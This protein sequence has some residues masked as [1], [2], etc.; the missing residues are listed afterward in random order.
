[1]IAWHHGAIAEINVMANIKHQTSLKE[2]SKTPRYTGEFEGAFKGDLNG[3]AETATR[4]AQPFNFI[5][6]GD[7]TGVVSSNGESQIMDVKVHKATEAE[8]AQ[9]SKYAEVARTV[10]RADN[11]SYAERAQTS[12][13]AN[14]AG[15]AEVAVSA[16][17]ADFASRANMAEQ[18]KVATAANKAELA[19]KANH[20]TNADNATHAKVADRLSNESEPVPYAKY[21]EKANLATMAQYDCEGRA[22][23]EYYLT[24]EEL[25]KGLLT[26]AQA[27]ALYAARKD[28]VL[29]A[30]VRGKA[31]GCG[32]VRGNTL[33]ILIKCI[34]CAPEDLN[35]D[36]YSAI[37]F[38]KNQVV[39]DN[40]DTTKIYI[41]SLGHIYFYNI[42]ADQWVQ[43][44]S[45][46]DVELL[47]DI[48]NAIANLN[49]LVDKTSDQEI[50]GIKKFVTKL[51]APIA[52]LESDDARDVVTVHNLKDVKSEL[53]NKFTNNSTNVQ[54]Q[55]D[56]IIARLDAQ[57]KGDLLYALVDYSLTENQNNMVVG[58]RYL[59][60][61]TEDKQYIQINP[62]TF[63]PQNPEQEP[64]WYRYYLKSDNGKVT[65]TDYSIQAEFKQYAQL[66][67]AEFT[68][69]ISVPDIPTSTKDNKVFNSKQ[70]H[71]LITE[72]LQDANLAQY[73]KLAGADFT[74]TVTVPLL[75][76]KSTA[77]DNQVLAKKDIEK[78]INEEIEKA[79]LDISVG[80][81][82]TA[83]KVKLLDAT[84]SDL[85]AESGGTAATPKAVKAVDTKVGNLDN[86]TTQE[87]TSVVGA[88]NEIVEKVNNVDV[89]IP[90]ATNS[91]KGLTLLS[92][93]INS[94]LNAASGNTAATPKAVKLIND[95]IGD[96][97]NLTT[98]NKTN[99][100][101]SV[102]ELNT[103]LNS[104][105]PI[106]DATEKAKGIIQIANQ[107][108]VLAGTVDNKAV[109]PKYLPNRLQP[110][111]KA[112][113]IYVSA[114]GN[115]LSADGTEENP[116]KTIA[117]AY[118]YL[119]NN[120]Y[121]IKGT[122]TIKV[123]SDLTEEPFD[124]TN[125][126]GANKYTNLFVTIDGTGHNVVLKSITVRDAMVYFK[127]I[128]FTQDD[129]IQTIIDCVC[130]SRLYLNDCTIKLN[131]SQEQNATGGYI[132]AR[133]YSFIDFFGTNYISCEGTIKGKNLF[134]L[135]AFSRL[136]FLGTSLDIQ[137]ELTLSG[138]FFNV[139]Q[140]SGIF[141]SATLAISNPEKLLGGKKYT[142]TNLSLL[143]SNGR[144]DS[145][146][147]G[148]TGSIDDSSVFN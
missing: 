124:Y 50:S 107:A 91:V 16:K 10:Q 109:V 46:I 40:A 147:P 27:D 117:D 134:S 69:N 22:F 148:T 137:N 79:D 53:E 44:T 14:E 9:N 1:M 31:Y 19:E 87:K 4:L 52:D 142:L 113:I 58:T 29:Q 63:L 92:D 32:V 104:I 94:S 41:T 100:V 120:F 68:G 55:L 45:P 110:I 72:K 81:D 136:N 21:A 144:G 90:D 77:T 5:L 121:F 47:E 25:P 43:I 131:K 28:L 66:D 135:Y 84:N 75:T 61:L 82:T 141:F 54:D 23:K 140:Q 42:D 78:L 130:F 20:A 64:Y 106:P 126:L 138:S 76:S 15:S 74:G 118:N 114:S 17:S 125:I 62:D 3:N 83:G 129:N 12:Q 57:A 122:A 105:N 112:I 115:N 6:N 34:T 88:I 71:A 7:A 80:N 99:V 38:T 143:Q 145:I 93:D 56:N 128:T 85:D 139:M 30:T 70:T 116:F 11:A 102:N 67:G 37:V 48:N 127:H 95:K 51:Q 108:E 39:P 33:D 111:T 13:F 36:L 132:V 65:W 49:N 89:E 133:Y 101:N 96:L 73:A 98:S 18:A 97:D 119:K 59:T 24:K 146:I 8:H 86:L 26:Q 123:I 2:A 60:Y 103:K 35:L